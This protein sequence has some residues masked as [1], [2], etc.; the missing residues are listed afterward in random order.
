[1]A[2]TLQGRILLAEDAPDLQRLHAFYLEAAGAKVVVATDGQAALEAALGSRGEGLP[3]S[4]ILM[5]LQTPRMDGLTATIRLR[6]SGWRWPIVA[7]SADAGDG[8]QS[9]CFMAGSDAFLRLPVGRED[10]VRACAAWIGAVGAMS[11]TSWI[12]SW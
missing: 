11:R 9:R 10:L 6:E 2:V 3:F 8:Q 12:V 7:L 5:D 4:L 1:M